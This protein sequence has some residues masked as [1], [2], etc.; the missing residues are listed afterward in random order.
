MGTNIK[1]ITVVAL[2]YATTV[3]W[4]CKK[5]ILGCTES[6][7]SFILNPQVYPDSDT[8][9]IS[10]TIWIEI[11]SATTLEDQISGQLIDYSNAN[12]IGTDMGFVKLINPSPIQLTNAVND[13]SFILIKGTE[14]ASRN[15]DLIKNYL[16]TENNGNIQFKLGIIPKDSGTFSFNLGNAIGVMR[17]GKSCPKADFQMLLTQTDQHY[18]L[19]PGGGGIIPTGADY[20]F[21]VR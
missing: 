12:N 19:Y 10:D 11:N 4:S 9:N 13:F 2:I 20:Y 15:P 18:Y 7:Y 14:E 1:L 3:Y 5:S 21:Y 6:S 16:L 17:N 8:I